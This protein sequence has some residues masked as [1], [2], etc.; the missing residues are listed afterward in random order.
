M[1]NKSHYKHQL[2]YFGDEFSHLKDYSLKEWHKTYIERIKLHL[3]DKQYQGKKLIDIGT[4]HGYVAIEMAKLGLD[5]IACDL[6]PE[7]L[8]NIRRFKKEFKLSNIELIHCKA[9]E[10][11][12]K[13]NSVDYIVANAILE[14]LPNE[15][16]AVNEWKRILR[17]SGK[18][19]ITV[20]LRYKYVLPFFIPLNYIHDKRVGHLRRYDLASLRRAFGLKVTQIFYTGHFIKVA[21]F[22]VSIILKT[23]KLFRFTEAIDIKSQHKKYGASNIIVV[24]QK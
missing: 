9:E 15:E 4:G 14:H 13:D 24:F 12:I 19:F 7:S 21:G 1:T 10:I 23:N 11:P 18:I 6:T 20:P 8:D 3:L 16:K 17:P 22:L 2:S 5:V